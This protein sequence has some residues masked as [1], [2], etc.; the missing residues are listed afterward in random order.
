MVASINTEDVIFILRECAAK[1]IMPLHGALEEHHIQKKGG[2]PNNLVTIADQQSEE[3][4]TQ[5]LMDL[6]PGS[7]VVG[8]EA[9]E[10]DPSILKLLE[11]PE[12][13]VWVIDPVDG[14]GNFSRGDETFCVLVAL[15]ADGKTQM[16]FIYD[17]SKDS[18]A[19]AI[20]GE[21]AYLDGKQIQIDQSVEIDDKP[22][23]VAMR[24]FQRH[25]HGNTQ[26]LRCSGLEY[27]RMSTGD[28]L[29]SIYGRT[30][31]WDH[32]AGTLIF[33]EAGGIVKRWDGSEYLPGNNNGGLIS[34]VN[35]KIWQTVKD[36]IPE[37]A[38]NRIIPKP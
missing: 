5:K 24:N 15:V 7:V 33:Q 26:T 20:R 17:P 2:D 22:G 1:I 9:V 4:L 10:D 25:G 31:P 6:L 13:I 32:L 8:E 18:I 14:T 27:Y 21:G 3:F 11:D 19:H 35:E 28:A 12:N 38:L 36:A 30:K 29:F 34:A 37:K 16:G 23:Y